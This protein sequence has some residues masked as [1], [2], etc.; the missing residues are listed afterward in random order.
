MKRRFDPPHRSLDQA[1]GF[2]ILS[3]TLSEKQVNCVPPDEIINAS[4]NN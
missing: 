1:Y 4:I 2:R 3:L